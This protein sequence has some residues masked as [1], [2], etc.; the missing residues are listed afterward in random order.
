MENL[1]YNPELV[2]QVIGSYFIVHSPPEG[3][4]K[5]MINPIDGRLRTCQLMMIADIFG[6]RAMMCFELT[7]N[8]THVSTT[9][10]LDYLNER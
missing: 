6:S 4:P 7:K 5:D 1:D 8:M 10:T 2:K 3:L 9:I